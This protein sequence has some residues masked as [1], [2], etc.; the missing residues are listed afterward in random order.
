MKKVEFPELTEEQ[1][2]EQYFDIIKKMNIDV[3]VISVEKQIAEVRINT[4]Y[5][6]Y[7]HRSSIIPDN[8]ISVLTPYEYHKEREQ[9]IFPWEIDYTDK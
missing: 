5:G 7:V 2:K 9:N 3:K 1:F 4:P 6:V 8:T